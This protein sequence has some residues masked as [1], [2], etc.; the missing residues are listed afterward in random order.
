MPSFKALE[1]K[2]GSDINFVS[3]GLYC[4]NEKW[5][6]MATDYAFKNN[7]FLGKEEE[8]QIKGYDVKFIPRYI[9]LDKDLKVIDALAPRP[10]SGDLQK[11]FK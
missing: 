7:M 11:Y 6:Q 2:Y 10:S 4:E 9:V 3:V 5:V 8:K 1:E